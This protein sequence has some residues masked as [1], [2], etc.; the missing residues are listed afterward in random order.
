MSQ[1][2][3]AMFASVAD[4]ERARTMLMDQLHL[5]ASA[6]RVSPT[7]GMADAGYDASKPYE[8]KGFFGGLKDLMV[9]DEDR[10]TY[11]EGLRR[12]H[13]LL[14]AEVEEAHMGRVSELL[15][16]AGAVDLDAQEASWRQAGWAGYK[17]SDKS[18]DH[19]ALRATDG[20]IQVAEERLVVGKRA[21]EAGS[22][23][24]RAYVVERPVEEQV[25]LRE[26]T[27]RI[28]RHPVDRAA[29][30]ADLASFGERTLEMTETDEVAV[31]GK[32]VRV[33]EEIGIRK[34]AADR[35]E[36]VRDTVRRTEV[37]VEDTTHTT[38]TGTAEGASVT[39]AGA[40][41]TGAAASV[42]RALGTD[43]TGA[44]PS[45]HAPDGTPGNPPGT[46]ASRAVDS[47]LGTNISGAN[48][49][50]KS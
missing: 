42:D 4:A 17:S 2:L 10:F 23:R 40:G 38:R 41:V 5:Q 50:H 20:T 35:V 30:A 21:I 48:P 16:Q 9:P 27:V 36:T 22:V 43:T 11:A 34:D 29:T 47:A 46:A 32:D 45:A 37:D 3:T 19:T 33:V 24:V 31:V 18:G 44:N 25:T 49:G 14:S 13:A 15:E 12:G 7:P 8:E 28:E 6:I 1:T 26:E 39:G